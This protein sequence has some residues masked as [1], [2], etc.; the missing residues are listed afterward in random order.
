VGPSRKKL[1]H[2][3]FVKGDIRT[4]A[5][6]SVSLL[7]GHHEINKHP[8]PFYFCHETLHHHGPKATRPSNHGLN[9]QNH[10]PKEYLTAFMLISSGNLPQ[11]WKTDVLTR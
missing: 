5:P 4:L 6:S 7:P 8:L 2:H 9:I 10:E 3:W 11:Q 1:V